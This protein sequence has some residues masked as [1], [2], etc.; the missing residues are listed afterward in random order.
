M[1][2]CNRLAV[3]CKQEV[4]EGERAHAG[5]PTFTEGTLLEGWWVWEASRDTKALWAANTAQTRGVSRM[6]DPDNLDVRSLKTQSYS[7]NRRVPFHRQEDREAHGRS[8]CVY[9]SQGWLVPN[10]M[11]TGEES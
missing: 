5:I 9:G 7:T 10:Y 11:Y 2:R 6:G 3:N 4:R 1:V 8:R